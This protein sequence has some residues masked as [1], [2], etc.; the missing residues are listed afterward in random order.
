[1]TNTKVFLSKNEGLEVLKK[2]NLDENV[3]AENLTIED[4]ASIANLIQGGK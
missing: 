1:L 3:R 4:F 2:L